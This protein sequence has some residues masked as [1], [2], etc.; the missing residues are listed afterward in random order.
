MAFVSWSD[1]A[2]QGEATT[3]LETVNKERCYSFSRL[4]DENLLVHCE[5][6]L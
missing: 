3:S 5:K 1:K 6:V 4:D 2:R